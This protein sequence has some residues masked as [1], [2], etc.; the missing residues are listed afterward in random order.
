ML[1][2]V[3]GNSSNNSENKIDTNIFVQKPYLRTNYIEAKIEE[4]IDVKKNNINWKSDF[5]LKI[6]DVVCKSYV[7]SALNDPSIIRNTAHI[8]FNDKNL[9]NFR[10]VT[11]N[12]L[13]AVREHLTPKIYVVEAFAPCV[14]EPSLLKLDPKE[15]LKI[16]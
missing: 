8:V 10:F 15:K 12:S 9:D 2:N 16:D 3:I 1:G 11:V 14:K 4:D 7:N 6:S 5:F 13:P